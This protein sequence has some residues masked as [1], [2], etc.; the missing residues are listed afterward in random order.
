[1]LAYAG[2]YATA[3]MKTL[4]VLRHGQAFPEADSDSDHERELTPRGRAEVGRVAE[5]LLER[6]SLPTLVLSSGA[7]RARQTAELCVAA[8]P[9]KVPLVVLDGLYLAEPPS[10]LSALSLRAEPHAAVLVVGHNPGLEALIYVLTACSE[11]LATAALVEMALPIAG[12]AEVS[13]EG[14]APGQIVTAIRP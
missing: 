7:V 6:Q 10:Y 14:L 5:A 1:M 9:G 12:W 2:S 11:H 4:Y 3:C 13:G 8:L